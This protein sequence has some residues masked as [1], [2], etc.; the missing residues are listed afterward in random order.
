[1][2]APRQKRKHS[3]SFNQF[4]TQGA[5]FGTCLGNLVHHARG[6]KHRLFRVMR[7]LRCCLEP[8]A[9]ALSTMCGADRP[10]LVRGMA[11]HRVLSTQ[12]RTFAE[13]KNCPSI[14]SKMGHI[15]VAIGA[16]ASVLVLY[17]AS[18]LDPD[19][20]ATASSSMLATMHAALK[21]LQT[22]R[23]SGHVS[24][25]A[26]TSLQAETRAMERAIAGCARGTLVAD[27]HNLAPLE[28]LEL[29]VAAARRAAWPAGEIVDAEAHE[30][31]L[32]RIA[33]G[34]IVETDSYLVV[35]QPLRAM[36]RAAPSPTG[37]VVVP[38]SAL[39]D[40]DGVQRA[41]LGAWSSGSSSTSG[42]S[43]TWSSSAGSS[44]GS[45]SS[46]ASDAGECDNVARVF[47]VTTV[48]EQAADMQLMAVEA[49]VVGS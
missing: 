48:A 3:N 34:E 4:A 15:G 32:T 7:A 14:D 28:R 18:A 43:W 25:D 27:A 16:T 41:G 8:A 26:A 47:A 37:S 12:G 11:C 17:A 40:L 30:M 23:F 39:P 2:K 19:D 36:E 46:A 29:Q 44:Y 13:L 22:W 42:S 6:N 33:A 5:I 31:L 9:T 10:H 35:S 21:A 49:T 20:A 38:L 24:D 45:A 1:M